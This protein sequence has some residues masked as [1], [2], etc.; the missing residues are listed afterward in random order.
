[1]IKHFLITGDIHGSIDRFTN[2]DTK[3]YPPEETG[4]IILGDAGFNY[5]LNLRDYILKAAAQKLGFTFYCVRG[6]HESRPEHIETIQK[7]YDKTVCHYV[8]YES[9]FPNIRYLIDGYDYYFLNKRTLIIGGAY[10]VDKEYRQLRGWAWWPDEQINETEKQFIETT[11]YNNHY[12]FVFTHTCPLS[13]EP[14]ELFLSCIDQSKVDNSMEKWLEEVEK[15][16]KYDFWLFGHFHGNKIINKKAAM[17]FEQI[18]DLSAIMPI[19]KYTEL[20][21]GFMI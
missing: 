2:I 12:N 15:N 17:L 18:L 8:Y 6:N 1:M 16:I 3:L 13:W 10:S 9:D 5:Y 19:D 20:P 4:I 14:T 11:H 21:E 7:I